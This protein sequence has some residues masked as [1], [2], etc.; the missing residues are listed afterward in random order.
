MNEEQYK[1]RIAV[2]EGFPSEGISFKDISTLLHDGEAL[3]SAIK[4]MADII[5]PYKPDYIVGPESR[6]FIFG[7]PIAVELGC[8]FIMARK[9]GKLPGKT[10]KVAYSLEYGESALE[11]PSY[12]LEKGKRVVMVD[13]LMATGGT[14]KA[15]EKVLL[16]AGM[17]VPLGVTF[18]EL[19]DLKGWEAIKA[20]FVSIVKYPH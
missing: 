16:E 18:I 2:Y 14:F 11:V 8:G 12:A 6:G 19:S 13:D 10:A 17:D 15:I 4:E 5:A 7:V 1:S 20:K 9:P 3:K